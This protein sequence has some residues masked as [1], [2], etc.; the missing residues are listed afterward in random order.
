MS[1]RDRIAIVFGGVS[2]E[3]EVSQCSAYNMSLALEEA[4]YE[5][6]HVGISKRGDFIPFLLEKEKLS[7]PNWEKL[8][9]EALASSDFAET[10]STG[11]KQMLH[12][13]DWFF[14]LCSGPVACVVLAVHGNNCEDGTLQGFFEL[15]DLP[16]TGADVLASALGM[17]KDLSKRLVADAGVPVWPHFLVRR[18]L[19]ISERVKTLKQILERFDFPLFIKPNCGGSSVGTAYCETKDELVAA[20]ENSFNYD[21]NLLVEPFIDARELEVAVL[22][23]HNYLAATP[24]EIVISSEAR[25]YD[26]ETKYLDPNASSVDMPAEIS[27][28]MRIKLK[29]FA[30]NVYRSLRCSGYARVDFFI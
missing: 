26:Y 12:P 24:G 15:C 10:K 11:F 19:F 4:G 3:H 18:D 6:A 16:Y 25:Y 2:T 29:N 7:D 21:E 30:I 27:E 1:K 17:D 8:A 9:L 14:E 28:G 23:N 20:L 22:G 13:R 5:I